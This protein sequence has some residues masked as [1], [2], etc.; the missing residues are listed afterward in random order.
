MNK[1]DP[2]KRSP[3]PKVPPKSQKKQ[4]TY[5]TVRGTPIIQ[6]KAS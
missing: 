5:T 4:S 6:G 1:A 2:K 3:K